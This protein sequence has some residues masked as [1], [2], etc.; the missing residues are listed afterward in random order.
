MTK[1]G[2][3]RPLL[4]PNRG[5]GKELPRDVDPG[6]PIAERPRNRRERRAAE[7]WQ[8]HNSDQRPRRKPTQWTPGLDWSVIPTDPQTTKDT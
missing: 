6:K 3:S 7:S 2:A 1:K 8:R 5:A 4:A